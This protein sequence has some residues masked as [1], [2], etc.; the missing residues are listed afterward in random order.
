MA[1]VARPCIQCGKVTTA[2]SYCKEHALARGRAR[3]KQR[4][5]NTERGYTAEYRKNRKEMLDYWPS[6][7]VC[8]H[9]GTEDNPLT[10][11]HI[12]PLSK[13]GTNDI[14]NLRSLCRYHNSQR[15]AGK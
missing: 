2:G 10:A 1:A 12:I 11:D 5:T 6:C 14:S 3:A 13:G 7:V 4:G 8:G 9:T 15:G